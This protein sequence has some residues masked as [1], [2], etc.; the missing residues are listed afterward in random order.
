[1]GGNVEETDPP[2]LL[3]E[4]CCSEKTP[5]E[6]DPN[7]LPAG[8]SLPIL[9]TAALLIECCFFSS[10]GPPS[11]VT[12]LGDPAKEA[13]E[14]VGN[15]LSLNRFGLKRPMLLD[16]LDSARDSLM[17]GAA[18]GRVGIE[19]RLRRCFDMRDGPLDTGSKIRRSTGSSLIVGCPSSIANSL[20]SAG[21]TFPAV[22]R[23]QISSL[24]IRLSGSSDKLLSLSD[25]TLRL[26]LD[27]DLEYTES[28]PGRPGCGSPW[29]G[30]SDKYPSSS[31][32]E[33]SLAFPALGAEFIVPKRKIDL[34]LRPPRVRSTSSESGLL[35]GCEVSLP[36]SLG[37]L[38]LRALA[39]LPN[40]G[41]LVIESMSKQF[42]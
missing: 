1:M 33:F 23:F 18:P 9:A 15:R 20:R 12:L 37:L 21:P 34:G 32:S 17:T 8:T 26:T 10:A 6:S 4:L 19:S 27:S 30:P 7:T 14:G 11:F 36:K 40:D 38:L 16:E 25:R 31:S 29:N 39:K 2:H 42:H 22:V 3:C 35:L 28:H 41:F 5:V 24:G 13:I